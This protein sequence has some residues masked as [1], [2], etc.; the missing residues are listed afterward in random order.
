MAV[1]NVAKVYCRNILILILCFNNRE[2]D[3]TMCFQCVLEQPLKYFFFFSLIAQICYPKV[4][5]LRINSSGDN[6]SN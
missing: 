6:K 1:K 5:V 3:T 4:I 2:N